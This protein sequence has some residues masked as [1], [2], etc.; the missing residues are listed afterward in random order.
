MSDEITKEIFLEEMQDFEENASKEIMSI[1]IDRQ[2]SLSVQVLGL[3]SIVRALITTYAHEDT[4]ALLSTAEYF[5]KLKQ[6]DME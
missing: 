5:L 4:E 3:I 2:Y 6:D 1:L